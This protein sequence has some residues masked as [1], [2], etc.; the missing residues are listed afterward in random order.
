MAGFSSWL[1]YDQ[2][3][4]VYACIAALR[5]TNPVANATCMHCLCAWAKHETR[6][7]LI[8]PLIIPSFYYM[9]A[10]HANNTVSPWTTNT[11]LSATD[12][13]QHYYICMWQDCQ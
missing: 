9:H 7:V 6:S 11:S 12:V 5:P 3:L 8:K 10:M 1:K 2:K 4:T 13:Q